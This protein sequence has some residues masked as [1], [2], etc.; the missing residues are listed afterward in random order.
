MKAKVT[1]IV[2]FVVTIWREREIGDI[3]DELMDT[4]KSV[5]EICTCEKEEQLF[6][7]FC[8]PPTTKKK[9]SL[10]KRALRE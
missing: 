3:S 1:I 5:C 7:I 4:E 10:K 2:A 8:F 6:F 9:G